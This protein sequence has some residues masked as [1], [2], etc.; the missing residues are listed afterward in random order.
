MCLRRFFTPHRGENYIFVSLKTLQ[1]LH[2]TFIHFLIPGK[3]THSD[4]YIERSIYWFQT[5]I[6]F[7]FPKTYYIL[8]VLYTGYPL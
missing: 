8:V 1:T 4:Q 2:F 7:K 3:Y 6:F 5:V